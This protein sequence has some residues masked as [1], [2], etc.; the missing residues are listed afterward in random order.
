MSSPHKKLKTKYLYFH[1]Q[2]W[3]SYLGKN[4]DFNFSI[5][6]C[7]SFLCGA[8][9]RPAF[10]SVCDFVLH[11]LF[12]FKEGE[13]RM[14]EREALQEQLNLYI[15]EHARLLN[16]LIEL[17]TA[18]L[19]QNYGIAMNLLSPEFSNEINLEQS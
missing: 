19:Q 11:T 4:A 2:K 14:E 6:E 1:I 5:F 17:R 9:R 13:Y 7:E 12:Y 10:F 16:L 15:K 18:L 3:A 8:K